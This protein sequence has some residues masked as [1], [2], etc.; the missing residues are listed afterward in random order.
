MRMHPILH[1]YKLHTGTDFAGGDGRI[2][3]AAGGTVVRAGY[4]VAYGNYVVIWHGQYNG[5]SVA[6]LYAHS[7]ALYVH[8]GQRVQTGDVI[9]LVGAT[10]Y[11]TGPHLHFEVR[12]AGRPVDPE[13]FLP[14]GVRAAA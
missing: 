6:T 9:G 3:A 10:G 5:W 2:H 14:G 11:A 1:E 13:L 7:A 12:L 8:K 4:D